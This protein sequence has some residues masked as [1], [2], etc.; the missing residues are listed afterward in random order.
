MKNLLKTKNWYLNQKC[1]LIILFKMYI[2]IQKKFKTIIYIK[3]YSFYTRIDWNLTQKNV[4]KIK[5]SPNSATG[6]YNI[7][8]QKVINS[9]A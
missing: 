6:L 2:E 7:V 9:G 3:I 8:H 4:I 5:N 1:L